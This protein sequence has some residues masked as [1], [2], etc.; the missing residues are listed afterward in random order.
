M[1]KVSFFVPGIPRPQG[2]K[3]HVGRG[4]MVES[5]KYVKDWRSLVSLAA[6]GAM[7]DAALMDGP[8]QMIV[9]FHFPRPKS[10]SKTKRLSVWHTSKPDASKLL[11]AAE[12]AMTGIVFGDDSQ[13]CVI[14]VSKVYDDHPGVRV[15][16][17]KRE[18]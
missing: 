10:H 1:N 2:S 15:H 4:I 14:D 9:S 13:L 5:S 17:F 11:R 16:V 12:D 3:R 18:D 6:K 7:G 8:L